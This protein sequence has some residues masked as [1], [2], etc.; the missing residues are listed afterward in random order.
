MTR[1]QPHYA[2]WEVSIVQW[3][4]YAHLIAPCVMTRKQ[5]YYAIWEVS[6]GIHA[7]DTLLNGAH[8]Y[9]LLVGNSVV[10]RQRT[11]ETVNLLVIADN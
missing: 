3:V 9:I 7:H 11:E 8:G 10:H 6:H 2:L 1:K 5:P 4:S